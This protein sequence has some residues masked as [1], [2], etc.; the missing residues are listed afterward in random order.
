MSIRGV[1]FDV[2]GTTIIESDPTLVVTSF[3]KAF[4]DHQVV[5]DEAVIQRNR[6]RDK[7][8]MIET[9]IHEQN[10]S[11]ALAPKIYHS[12][13]SNIVSNLHQFR[14]QRGAT[15]IFNY[16]R[17][18]NIKIGLGTGLSRDLF[19]Q[20]LNHLQWNLADFDYI[21]IANEMGE[22]RPS[23]IMIY[24]MMKKLGISNAKEFL[25]V[26]DTTADIQEGKNAGVV[27]VAIL[28]GTQTH[29]QL[30]GEEPDYIISDLSEIK[31]II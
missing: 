12:F 1:L 11:V 4:E 16:L 17:K 25:K 30:E 20:I 27:T 9:V 22:S 24:D 23:P 3:K 28:S 19:E 26:G 21:G 10:L 2:I 7:M 6:G 15:E 8:L 29:E 31:N 18:Q 13:Q 14:S 5:V